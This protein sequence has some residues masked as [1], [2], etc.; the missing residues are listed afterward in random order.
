MRNK[1]IAKNEKHEKVVKIANPANMIEIFNFRKKF[2]KNQK[3]TKNTQ[4]W[5]TFCAETNAS[6]IAS[7]TYENGTAL[8]QTL[9]SNYHLFYESRYTTLRQTTCTA[10]FHNLAKEGH[11]P[12]NPKMHFLP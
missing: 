2:P 12:L 1:K 5:A 3:I 11:S 10:V 9:H 7:W 6:E 4:K 8:K